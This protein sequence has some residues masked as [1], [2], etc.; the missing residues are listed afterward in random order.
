MYI[1][2]YVYMYA[3]FKQLTLDSCYNLMRPVY[4]KRSNSCY[5]VI[6]AV[7]STAL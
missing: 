4:T 1:C 6:A 5:Q 7:I 2:I 3:V